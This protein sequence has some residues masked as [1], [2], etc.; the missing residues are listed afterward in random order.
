MIFHPD[1]TEIY[2]PDFSTWVSEERVS[3][4]L[5]GASRPGH[6]RGVCTVVLKLFAI[7]QPAAAVFG[8]KDFQQFMVL[9]RMVRDLNLPVRM[10]GVET[11]REPDGLA[12]SSRNR[13]LTAEE[14]I[15]APVLRQALLAA[16][17]AF[18]AGEANAAKLRRQI[19]KKIAGAP[20]A[21]LDYVEV[22]DSATLEERKTVGPGTVFALAVYFGKT[23][24]IDNLWLR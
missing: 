16:E 15:Q 19:L 10:I 22:R 11:V 4:P 7:V 20:L 24:L 14:R 9:R 5:C 18:Q 13:Y 8:L 3:G 2:A 23:R 21:H 12:L 6:F 1:A 17:R